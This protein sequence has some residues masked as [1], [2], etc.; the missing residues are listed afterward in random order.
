MSVSSACSRVVTLDDA[1]SAVYSGFI[2]EEE[3]TVSSFRALT[4]VID[5]HGLFC[6]LYSDRGSY[7]FHTPKAGEPVSKSV[8]TQV[9]RALAQL[10][11]PPHRG[12]FARGMNSLGD[13]RDGLSTDMARVGQTGDGHTLLL[14]FC[15]PAFRG[16]SP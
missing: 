2:V 11:I 1:T 15:G 10:G 5:Q 4:E 14:S 13:S 7:Y 3:G 9:G 12:L 8:Q 16:C 6:E